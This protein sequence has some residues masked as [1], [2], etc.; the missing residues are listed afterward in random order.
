[1]FDIGWSEMAVIALLAL[2][3][4]GPKDLPKAM[5][6]AAHWVRKARAVARE[7]QS[8]IDDMM[9]EAELDE[10]KKSIESARQFNVR[11]Q[12]EDTFDPTGE[13]D[14]EARD[15]ERTARSEAGESDGNGGSARAE[16][17]KSPVQMAPGNS[18][19]PPAEDSTDTS[20]VSGTPGQTKAAT[21]SSGTKSASA[22]SSSAKK[23][24]TKAKAS[25]SGGS[26]SKSTATKS[27]SANKST[28][29]AKSG[30]AKKSGG[31]RVVRKAKT[32]RGETGDKAVRRGG[33]KSSSNAAKGDS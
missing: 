13:V 7:F 18:V 10:A 30:S 15:L 24:G 14:E 17:R 29:R 22:R 3:V 8:G 26:K 33:A 16:V 23:A 5:Q 12:I 6:A 19:K 1:M 2:I 21:K 4:L 9:R 28:S 11:K 25:K 32:S 20:Q 27:A 31:G